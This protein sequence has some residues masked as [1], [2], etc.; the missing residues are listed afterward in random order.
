MAFYPDITVDAAFIIN[1]IFDV[2]FIID[3]IINFHTGFEYH[4]E[5]VME[6]SYCRKHYFFGNFK[7]DVLASI[8]IDYLAFF[9]SGGDNGTMLKA[10]R[11]IRVLRMFR[12]IR[13]F[14]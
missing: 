11:L 9:N 5:L 10:P 6:I 4:G 14:R 8:P 12:L 3:I 1:S 7:F 2:F 13:L